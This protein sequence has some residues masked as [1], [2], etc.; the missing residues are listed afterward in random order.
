MT[1]LCRS[2]REQIWTALRRIFICFGEPKAH[3]RSLGVAVSRPFA[4]KKAKGWGT[5]LVQN[6][7]VRKLAF[8]RGADAAGL[9]GH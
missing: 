8:L 9:H 2:L 1:I 5:E 4:R 6:E 3:G 7:A